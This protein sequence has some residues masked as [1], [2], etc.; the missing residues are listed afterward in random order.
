MN[1]WNTRVSSLISLPL[2][3]GKGFRFPWVRFT[4]SF[5]GFL[6]LFPSLPTSHLL[7]ASGGLQPES[8]P[9]AFLLGTSVYYKE[10]KTAI[11][12][13]QLSKRL[14]CWLSIHFYFFCYIFLC[15]LYNICMYLVVLGIEA[16]VLHLASAQ[17]F[18]LDSYLFPLVF[19]MGSHTFACPVLTPQSAYLCLPN[20]WDYSHVPPRSALLFFF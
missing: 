1:H 13:I 19:Q 4:V 16:R 10:A 2:R 12:F 14:K 11:N 20:S 9:G 8:C 15:Y 18:E 3:G 17:P 6:Y 7:L 5:S